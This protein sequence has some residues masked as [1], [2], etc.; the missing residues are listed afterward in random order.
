VVAIQGGQQGESLRGYGDRGCGV[1]EEDCL[2]PLHPVRVSNL[3]AIC[4]S[5]C[6][7]ENAAPNYRTRKGRLLES[8]P[9]GATTRTV[10]VVAPEGT[11]LWHG[12]QNRPKRQ[13]DGVIQLL[14]PAPYPPKA[15]VRTAW[16]VSRNLVEIFLSAFVT[17]ARLKSLSNRYR[18]CYP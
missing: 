2:G 12:L 14:R 6:S 3:V 5:T 17:F 15:D 13:P 4:L 9:V 11:L 1:Q 7:C 16:A 8:V 10:P 18:C